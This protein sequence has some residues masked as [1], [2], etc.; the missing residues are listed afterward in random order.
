M[1]QLQSHTVCCTT[2][3]TY[4]LIG[5]EVPYM[6]P[7]TSLACSQR[8]VKSTSHALLAVPTY[9]PR[10]RAHTLPHTCSCDQP[11]IGRPKN[12]EAARACPGR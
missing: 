8:E 9:W 2:V 6:R 12:T 4:I 5:S 7:H 10:V 11:A 1:L 3:H